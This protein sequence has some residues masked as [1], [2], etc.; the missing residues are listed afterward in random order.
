[1]RAAVVD[2]VD[3]QHRV[4]RN[5]EARA[6]VE[7]L[8]RRVLE[9]VVD[10]VDA[11]G[12]RA[13]Q[14]EAGERVG[15]GRGERR[16]CPRVRIQEE[17]VAG[18]HFDRQRAA[19]EAA[20]ERDDLERDAVVV[21]APAA[22]QLEGAALAQPLEADAR[23]EIVVVALP[24]ALQKG[25]HDRVDVA[26]ARDVLDVGVDLVAQ[27]R[28]ERE[29]GRHAPVVLHEAGDV[30]AAAVVEQQ[31]LVGQ[32]AP[33]RDREQQVVVVHA[34]VAVQVELREVLDELDTPVAED[35]EVEPAVCVRELRAHPQRV[36]ALHPRQRVRELPALLGRALRHAEA[37]AVLDA[38][39]RELPA[40]AHGVDLVAELAVARSQ[41]VDARRAHH[42][43]PRKEPLLVAVVARP[44]ARC[45]EP[46][47]RS[48]L[49][50]AV[51][52]S[53]CSR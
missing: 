16:H 42:A 44:G 2:V 33:E 20:L 35:A 24:V 51:S 41:R 48:S 31:V 15:E 5:L 10:D 29:L 13:R 46:S 22:V 50:A 23:P 4:A 53:S 26:V 37:R 27:A 9:R 43:R 21:E 12:A 3:L 30:V 1:M 28:V 34:A 7:L 47:P 17:D 25:L 40:R 14:D 39:E 49:L 6:E 36:G 45:P 8:H 18:P 11:R 32:A 38:R 19:V 52:D